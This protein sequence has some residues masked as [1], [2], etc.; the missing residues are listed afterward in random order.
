[1][2]IRVQLSNDTAHWMNIGVGVTVLPAIHDQYIFS[3]DEVL[4][5]SY[6]HDVPVLITIIGRRCINDRKKF[7]ARFELDEIEFFVL[8]I[9]DLPSGVV[10]MTEI[11]EGLILRRIAL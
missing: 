9:D 5:Y 10:K 8:I 3:D 4:Q 7:E 11:V 1:M 6:V 2:T